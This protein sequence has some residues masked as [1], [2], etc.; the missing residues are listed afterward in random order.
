MWLQINNYIKLEE[1]NKAIASENTD[2]Y[3]ITY[4]SA[5][6]NDMLVKNNE[7]SDIVRTYLIDCKLENGTPYLYRGIK[8]LQIVH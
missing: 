5:S 8:W 3:S 7:L 2:G 1:Q 4:K 6:S